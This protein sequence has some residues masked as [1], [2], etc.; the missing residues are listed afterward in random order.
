MDDIFRLG[1]NYS[2]IEERQ[3]VGLWVGQTEQIH[4]GRREGAAEIV[5]KSHASSIKM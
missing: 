4:G 3:E 1:V 2:F 5:D